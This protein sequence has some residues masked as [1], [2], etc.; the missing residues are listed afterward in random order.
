MKKAFKISAVVLMLVVLIAAAVA[1]AVNAAE[2]APVHLTDANLAMTVMRDGGNFILDDNITCDEGVEIGKNITLDLNGHTMEIQCTA[3]AFHSSATAGGQCTFTV[4]DSKGGG[5]ILCDGPLFERRSGVANIEGGTIKVGGN[6]IAA[7][8][9]NVTVLFSGHGAEAGKPDG[10]TWVNID[11]NVLDSN[12]HVESHYWGY[13]KG[14]KEIEGWEAPSKYDNQDSP[15]F[16]QI[17]PK[18]YNLTY[19]KELSNGTVVELSKEERGNNPHDTFSI[20]TEPFNLNDPVTPNGY[21]NVKWTYRIVRENNVDHEFTGPI[22]GRTSNGEPNVE[23]LH[24]LYIVAHFALKTYNITYQLDGAEDPGNPATFTVETPTITLKNPTRKGATFDGWYDA[25]VGGKKV[26]EIKCAETY[27]N[28]ELYARFN[29][30]TYKI[31]YKFVN[32]SKDGA[33]VSSLTPPA[34]A[35]ETY[36]VRDTVKFDTPAVKNTGYKFEKWTLESTG[37]TITEI[38]P[39]TLTGE[40]TVVGHVT[41][42]KFDIH[43]NF[44][45]PNGN[46]LDIKPDNFD[47]FPQTY[48]IEDASVALPGAKDVEMKRGRLFKGFKDADGKD[49]TSFKPTEHLDDENGYTVDC[50]MDYEYYAITWK[51]GEGVPYADVENP[52]MGD[53]KGDGSGYYD[54]QV[55]TCDD[56][57][58][59]KD[60]IRAHYDFKGWID[61]ST[62]EP[63]TKIDGDA[64]YRDITLV[65]TWELH[66]Y[67]ITYGGLDGGT[68]PETYT[69]EYTIEDDVTLPTPTKP[70][71]DFVGW[72]DEGGYDVDDWKAGERDGDIKL[73]VKGWTPANYTFTIIYKMAKEYQA[74]NDISDADA[75]LY[76]VENVTATYGEEFDHVVE[77]A[78]KECNGFVPYLWHVYNEKFPVLTEHA[79]YESN[80]VVNKKGEK[81]NALVV[82]FMP[83]VMKTEL[84]GT[85]LVVTYSNGKTKTVDLSSFKEITVEGNSLV[86]V[87]TD[88]TK[89]TLATSADVSKLE[90]DMN[91]KIDAL[92]KEIANLKA[93][94]SSLESKTDAALKEQVA[95]LTAKI[96]ELTGVNEQH[97]N[98]LQQQVNGIDTD[99]K[100]IDT[101][102]PTWIIV[103][104]VIVAVVAVA[105]LAWTVVITFKKKA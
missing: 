56:E 40:I 82:Y 103:L 34:G 45:D 61:E 79:N 88:G 38:K 6:A 33:A 50:V 23:I 52:N 81:G 101:S 96:N 30:Q 28:V 91:A 65:A 70:G 2:D 19:V 97:L 69:S 67:K 51:Y 75:I 32:D 16:Y 93:D 7:E 43:Y 15:T 60:A 59:L 26:T 4:K 76:V 85:N 92:N 39:D 89:Y 14:D 72:V 80:I 86:Y 9:C 74:E 8:G 35:P 104:L 49:V 84:N 27:D 102:V 31:N 62:N 22:S 48:T 54:R 64:L 12:T 3:G 77:F 47:S 53:S 99:V 24:N 58:E 100:G 21:T 98:A 25:A 36:T 41:Y 83:V 105:A 18:R 46:K 10:T 29:Y 87:T 66:K 37:E 95:Q 13:L 63:V 1:I 94:L 42:F 57:F 68:M 17:L 20:D 55:F 11:P 44:V 71:C 90:T 5:A 78:I 73:S